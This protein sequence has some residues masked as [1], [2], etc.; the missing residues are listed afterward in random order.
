MDFDEEVN[1]IILL[2]LVASEV[3]NLLNILPKSRR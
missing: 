1:D 3:T 2:F